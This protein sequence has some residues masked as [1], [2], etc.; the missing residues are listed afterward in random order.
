MRPAPPWFNLAWWIRQ[1]IVLAKTSADEAVAEDGRAVVD[2]LRVAEAAQ[3]AV[4]AVRR[5]D[6]GGVVHAETVDDVRS[7]VKYP[8]QNALPPKRACRRCMPRIQRS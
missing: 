3:P 5:K 2:E 1:I 4:A 7:H 6:R 8:T